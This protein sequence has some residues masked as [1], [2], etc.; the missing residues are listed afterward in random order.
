MLGDV[1]DETFP[2]PL[3]AVADVALQA[4]R[5]V[6]V[7]G[8]LTPVNAHVERARLV[9]ELS[10]GRAAIP[11]WTYAPWR[12]DEVQ[13]RLDAAEELLARQE[14]TAITDVYADRVRELALEATICASVGTVDVARLARARF[15]PVTASE[16]RRALALSAQWLKDPEPS[17]PTET[18]LSDAADPLSLLSQLKAGVSQLRLPFAVVVKP[19]LAALAATGDGFIFVAP[20][21]PVTHEDT[22][23]TVLHELH[24]HASPRT[25]ALTS[26]YS[27]FRCGTARGVDDQEG[28]ALLLEEHGERLKTRRR[29][30]LAIRHHAFETMASGASF[31]D[32]SRMLTKDHGV[33]PFDAVVVCERIFR[34]GDGA[35]PG[36]GRERVYLEALVRVKAHLEAHPED[37]RILASGQ[38]STHAA[39]ALRA[40][41]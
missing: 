23:R 28:Y 9:E 16:A 6:Q 27:I 11:R 2:P 33:P 31:A 22:A 34:G 19:T 36:L 18:V 38:V 24:G 20:G 29:H 35:G 12:G 17:R 32:V 14:A 10:A 4:S 37:E 26:P 25:R 41:V 15:G 3:R 39:P 21:R 7:L 5:E 30:Q 1:L 13:R 40:L 8:A